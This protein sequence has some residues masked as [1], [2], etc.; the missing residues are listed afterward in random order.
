MNGAAHRIGWLSVCRSFRCG[1]TRRAIEDPSPR[2]NLSNNASAL[3]RAKSLLSL[4]PAGIAS[5]LRMKP[6]RR[7]GPQRTHVRLVGA[8]HG[9]RPS[10]APAFE[11]EIRNG[12]RKREKRGIG[13]LLRVMRATL[14]YSPD[15]FS[16]RLG[17][18]RLP[19]RP[20]PP[21]RQRADNGSL[22]HHRRSRSRRFV[23]VSGA[24]A[25]R[26][27]LHQTGDS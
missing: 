7:Q 3:L 5:G 15:S 8:R 10:A 1:P 23:Q 17:L 24:I 21:P 25:C 6:Q 9:Q 22:R 13:C 14:A 4:R 11:R 19:G 20:A 12:R 18:R 27:G 16:P 2:Q 26:N